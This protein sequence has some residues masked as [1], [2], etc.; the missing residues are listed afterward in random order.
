MTASFLVNLVP[1]AMLYAAGFLLWVLSLKVNAL[2]NTNSYLV[3]Q[4]YGWQN[5]LYSLFLATYQTLFLYVVLQFNC[6]DFATLLNKLSYYTCLL[7]S[8][9]LVAATGAYFRFVFTR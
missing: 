8:A 4:K 9:Y 3:A 2:R 6:Q 1:V 7:I 5:L